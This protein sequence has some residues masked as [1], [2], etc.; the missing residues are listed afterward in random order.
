MRFRVVADNVRTHA[1]L[2]FKALGYAPISE[3]PESDPNR[4]IQENVM[5]LLEVFG[6][7]GHSGSSAPFAIA[8]FEK[9]AKWEPLSPLTGEPWE[10]M[11][12][13]EYGLPEGLVELYQNRR[14]G[15]VF[16][17]VAK[18]GKEYC[19]DI[20]GKVFREPNGVCFTN[21]E[22]RTEVA[23]PYTPK[24]EYVDRPFSEES[25]RM[26]R[27][28]Q[29]KGIELDPV[30]LAAIAKLNWRA[31]LGLTRKAVF[32]NAVERNLRASVDVYPTATQ[33][34]FRS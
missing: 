6:R 30:E 24:T 7:Q 21:R 18:D 2:E 16:K 27:E 15:H 13:A 8:Y 4:W 17:E 20:D 31:S 22:S 26:I 34:L 12:V 1:E 23:F 28:N 25:L 10:W 14:C 33:G 3:L 29:A 9:L 32:Q 5:E 19:Y 11:S